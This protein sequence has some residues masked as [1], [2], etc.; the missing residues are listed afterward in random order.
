MGISDGTRFD[1]LGPTLTVTTQP[2]EPAGGDTVTATAVLTND[3]P[4]P[5]LN[6]VLHLINPRATTAAKT[7]PLGDLRPG[8]KTTRHWETAIPADVAGDVSFTAHVVFD[9]N[10]RSSDCARSAKAF[11]V[12]YEP[13]GVRDPYRTFATTDDA[14][15]G[16]YGSQLV[17]WAG[18][19]D[20]S[21]GTDEKG[22]SSFPAPPPSRAWCRSRR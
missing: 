15:F 10:E 3:C 16:Q 20:F 5:L 14:K 2:A 13:N 4:F 7:I 8:T 11:T 9:V 22:A 6:A 19:R 21:G 17:I 1:A 18:G 12:P